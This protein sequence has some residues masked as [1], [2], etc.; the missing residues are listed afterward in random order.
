MPIIFSLLVII[1]F[2]KDMSPQDVVNAINEA[3]KNRK[4]RR[5]NVYIGN[6]KTGIEIKMFIDENGKIISAFPSEQE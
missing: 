2:S 3:Y 5:G 1:I 4:L 6:S